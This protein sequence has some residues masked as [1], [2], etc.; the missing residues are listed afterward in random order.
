[1]PWDSPPEPERLSPLPDID[2][3]ESLSVALAEAE[4][5]SVLVSLAEPELLSE[6]E[7]E[8]STLGM[9]LESFFQHIEVGAEGPLVNVDVS[10]DS[11]TFDRLVQMVITGVQS[12]A[13]AASSALEESAV[14]AEAEAES[15]L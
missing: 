10:L 13:A 6:A 9:G 1:M 2:A 11:E 12:F 14:E 5:L 7:A 15:G 8:A 4:L 3:P